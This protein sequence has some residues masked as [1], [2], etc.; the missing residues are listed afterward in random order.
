M[1]G[2]SEG[3]VNMGDSMGD[4]HDLMSGLMSGGDSSLGGEIMDAFGSGNGLVDGM[5][6]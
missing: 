1:P 3:D 6:F 4:D 2:M 5:G